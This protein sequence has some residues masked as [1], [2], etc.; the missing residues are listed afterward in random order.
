MDDNR[1]KVK[2]QPELTPVRLEDRIDLKAAIDVHVESNLKGISRVGLVVAG[3]GLLS[4]VG[5]CVLFG[6][7]YPDPWYDGT[8]E[9]HRVIEMVVVAASLGIIL[10]FLGTTM[11]F[12]GRSVIG[13]GRLDNFSMQQAIEPHQAPPPETGG[14]A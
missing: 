9:A 5:G 6:L 8:A 7:N 14:A 2:L 1:I 13:K 4:L 12:Y 3:L 10:L 11:F